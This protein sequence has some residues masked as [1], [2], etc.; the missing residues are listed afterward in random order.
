DYAAGYDSNT[1]RDADC[2]ANAACCR[3][4]R[5]SVKKNQTAC[6]GRM[7]TGV[8][9]DRASVG[10]QRI[11]DVDCAVLHV[12][13]GELG[14]VFILVL[15]A[16]SSLFIGGIPFGSADRS[17]CVGGVNLEGRGAP[18]HRADY[19]RMQLAAEQS[20]L[21]RSADAIDQHAFIDG[22]RGA[23]TEL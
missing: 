12:D 21:A 4:A 23:W 16:R 9:V 5:C 13:V 7:M 20:D 6:D 14:A 17:D 15:V 8:D 22:E 18:A 2:S 10:V 19:H 3:A 1:D 11:G